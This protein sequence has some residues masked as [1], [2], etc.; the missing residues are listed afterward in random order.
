MRFSVSCGVDGIT[1][2]NCCPAGGPGGGAIAATVPS[3]CC[4]VQTSRNS[5]CSAC[6]AGPRTW[7]IVSRQPFSSALSA[8]WPLPSAASVVAA[9]GLGGFDDPR[10][11]KPPEPD[12][13]T[14]LM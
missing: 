14:A 6:V 12:E 3:Q 11:P 13:Y 2:I 7:T 8:D 1:R 4:W 10:P 9:F 5:V